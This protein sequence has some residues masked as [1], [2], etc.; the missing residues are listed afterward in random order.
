MREDSLGGGAAVTSVFITVVKTFCQLKYSMGSV[1]YTHCILYHVQEHKVA[2]LK[3]I[4]AVPCVILHIVTFHMWYS[5]IHLVYVITFTARF[6][7]IS[8]THTKQ[9]GLGVPEEWLWPC[10][11]TMSLMWYATP[12]TSQSIPHMCAQNNRVY[13][14]KFTGLGAASLVTFSSLI[15]GF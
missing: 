8:L 3:S 6:F 2:L 14:L 11:E 10:T 9:N 15:G 12:Y 7:T 1:H 5:I 13:K 4:S